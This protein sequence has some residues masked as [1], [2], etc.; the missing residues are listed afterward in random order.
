MKNYAIKEHHL[1]N[2]AFRQGQRFVGRLVA[3]YVL[4]DYAAKRLMLQNPEKQYLNRVGLSVGKRLGG[5]VARNRAKRL[6]R[7]AYA[8]VKRQPG[9]RTGYLVVLA[10]RDEICGKKTGDV[11][12]ELRRAFRTLGLLLEE[13]R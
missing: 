8:A 5:A 1:Y 4:R 10:A 12:K 3:V 11:E 9:L 6:L 7:E 2:K 13:K